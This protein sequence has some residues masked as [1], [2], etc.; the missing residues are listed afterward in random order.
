MTSQAKE[1]QRTRRSDMPTT[2]PSHPGLE[3]EHPLNTGQR[4][5]RPLV[6]VLLLPIYLSPLLLQESQAW[7]SVY[8]MALTLSLLLSNEFPSMAAALLPLVLA[9]LLG[10]ADA[11][12]L[13]PH[14]MDGTV[15]SLACAQCL[16]GV[17]ASGSN[18]VARFSCALLGVLGLRLLGVGIVAASLVAGSVLPASHPALL[19]AVRLVERVVGD[20][21]ADA[22]DAQRR[23]DGWFDYAHAAPRTTRAMSNDDLFAQLASTVVSLPAKRSTASHRRSSRFHHFSGHTAPDVSPDDASQLSAQASAARR[24]ASTMRRRLSRMLSFSA[25]AGA[26]RKSR[27]KSICL[28]KLQPVEAPPAWAAPHRGTITRRLTAHDATTGG[29]RSRRSTV[30]ATFGISEPA[31]VA[32]SRRTSQ[33]LGRLPKPALRQEAATPGAP[34]PTAMGGAPTD[35]GKSEGAIPLRL[36]SLSTAGPGKNVDATKHSTKK[37]I[38][39]NAVAPVLPR[40]SQAPIWK[41]EERPAQPTTGKTSPK[42]AMKDSRRKCLA[43]RKATLIDPPQLDA[44][45]DVSSVSLRPQ[46]LP[47]GKRRQS[48]APPRPTSPMSSTL[49]S[50]SVQTAPIN[51]RLRLEHKGASALPHGLQDATTTFQGSSQKDAQPGPVPQPVEEQGAM[52]MSAHFAPELLALD[53]DLLRKPSILKPVRVTISRTSATPE[54]ED[55]A[56]KEAMRQRRAADLDVPTSASQG[57]DPRTPEP[58][59]SRPRMISIAPRVQLVQWERSGAS[60]TTDRED[61]HSSNLSFDEEEEADRIRGMFKR[62]K[63]TLLVAVCF[64]SAFGGISNFLLGPATASLLANLQNSD[65]DEQVNAL[66]WCLVN[67]PA[68]LAASVCSFFYVIYAGLFSWEGEAI[69]RAEEDARQKVAERW[70]RQG[71][72]S[73]ADLLLGYMFTAFSIFYVSWSY[74][75]AYDVCAT[76]PAL[77]GT[78]LLLSAL[79][80]GQDQRS[81]ESGRR[82]LDWDTVRSHVSW[83]LLLVCGSTS[84]LSQMAE[85]HNLVRAVFDNVDMAFWK[86][87]SPVT[88]QLLMAFTAAGFAELINS[89]PLCNLIMPVASVSTTNP[90]LYAI[91]VAAAA[92]SNLIFPSSIPVVILRNSLEM[93]TSE[94]VVVGLVLKAVLVVSAVLSTNTV[95]RLLFEAKSKRL[96]SAMPSVTTL[97]LNASLTAAPFE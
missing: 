5:Y 56:A 92:S 52:H 87:R 93:R 35:S 37:M 44:K 23:G 30:G 11:Q 62:L 72:C 50:S 25:A 67:F 88:I 97:M 33:A 73:Y 24:R 27:A 58:L 84:M 55:G 66:Q 78:V 22:L 77:C 80:S 34:T 75:T 39:L 68:S 32:V 9:P 46:P 42:S 95:G 70:K 63:N 26:R 47:A 90:V 82:I 14:Y 29:Q 1:A 65:A 59:P 48:L 69:K 94:A 54:S 64:N 40:E 3:E 85:R 41:N 4:R 57:S 16:V 86:A 13:A 15:L 2:V 18:L 31:S 49:D 79:P 89:M 43:A 6:L 38:A 17:L 53:G 51:K 12:M 7:K 71:K 60:G 83:T 76:L 19:L 74:A 45:C 36:R 28:P 96:E 10:L 20:L 61:S 21:E 91:P 8:C 81:W